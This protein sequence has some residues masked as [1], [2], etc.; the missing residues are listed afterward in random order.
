MKRLLILFFVLN[1]FV[2]AQNSVK[3]FY[4]RTEKGRPLVLPKGKLEIDVGPVFMSGRDNWIKPWVNIRYAITKNLEIE[5]I[6][7]RYRF[8]NKELWQAAAVLENYGIGKSEGVIYHHSKFELEAKYITK[9]FY[10]LLFQCGYY[11][12]QGHESEGRNDGQSNELRLTAAMPIKLYYSNSI[13]LTGGLRFY[14]YE[15]YGGGSAFFFKLSTSQNISDNV[16]FVLE[17]ALSTFNE[18][19]DAVLYNES[20][21]KQINFR[22]RW[23]FF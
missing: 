18:A 6:G 14:N 11:F 8:L 1:S 21:D 19:T 22:I 7:L 20:Y 23:R 2:Y 15:A 5:R 12:A 16:D 9:T 13:T 4:P 17:M 10:A 3:N